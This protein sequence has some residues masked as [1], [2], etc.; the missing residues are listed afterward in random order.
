MRAQRV[1]AVCELK[2]A[3][4]MGPE[5]GILYA[6]IDLEDGI[7]GKLV[8]D[9]AGHYNRADVFQLRV[10]AMT[11]PIYNLVQSPSPVT[12]SL[13]SASGR[14]EGSAKAIEAGP[15]A[16]IAESFRLEE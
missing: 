12:G 8:H 15:A 9:F 13:L 1:D 16:P 2:R 7:R 3:G 4:P 6:D 14:S 10:S 5:E 11:P